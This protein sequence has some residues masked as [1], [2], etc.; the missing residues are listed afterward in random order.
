M[1]EHTHQHM[2]VGMPGAHLRTVGVGTSIGHGQDA[3]SGVLEGEVLISKLL[4]I[5]GLTTSAITSGEV[6]TL[7]NQ[8][9][10]G[11]YDHLKTL[12][13]LWT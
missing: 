3:W 10:H 2:Y 8:K 5:D 9:G 1:H 11:G 13:Q 6:T 12:I 7:R 4:T